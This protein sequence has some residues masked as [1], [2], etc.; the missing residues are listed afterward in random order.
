M[1]GK[2]NWSFFILV[3]ISVLEGNPIKKFNNDST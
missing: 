1:V 3:K 2:K